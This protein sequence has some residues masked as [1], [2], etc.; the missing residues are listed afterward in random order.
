VRT[1]IVLP[2]SLLR[3]A[4]A[5]SAAQGESLKSLIT[6]AVSAE[7]AARPRATRV[8]LPPV[9]NPSGPKVRV[10]N[11]DLA[12]RLAAAGAQAARPGGRSRVGD[13]RRQG[14]GGL[15]RDPV[16]G[17]ALTPH[18]DARRPSQRTMTSRHTAPTGIQGV[19][20]AQ[21]SSR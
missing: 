2:P 3:A 1:T 21:V 7:V 15:P 4:K 19:G 5:R 14:A 10:T 18:M 17:P 12:D 20:G 11:R 8:V 16:A 9:G 13:T 6:R